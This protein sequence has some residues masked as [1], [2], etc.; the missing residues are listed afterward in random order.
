MTLVIDLSP[1]EETWLEA[2][3]QQTGLTPNML[4]T[5]LLRER[6]PSLIPPEI[7]S[8]E[9]RVAAIWAAV[10]SMAHIGVGVEDLHRERQSDKQKE[11]A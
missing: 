7:A 4:V 3:A 10:G 1:T 11:E 6:M 5:K 8:E 2:A 9:A